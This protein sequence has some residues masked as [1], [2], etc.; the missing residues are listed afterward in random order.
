MLW[1][2]GEERLEKGER[3]A[4]GFAGLGDEAVDNVVA[5]LVLVCEALQERV[6]GEHVAL[7]GRPDKAER[8]SVSHRASRASKLDARDEPAADHSDGIHR[9]PAV[10]EVPG[11]SKDRKCRCGKR[12]AVGVM[13]AVAEQLN[14]ER[15]DQVKG[16]ARVVQDE[17]RHAPAL[18]FEEQAAAASE[19]VFQQV[20]EEERVETEQEG[21]DAIDVRVGRDK[22]KVGLWLLRRAVM[23]RGIGRK[24]W[25]AHDDEAVVGE[26]AYEKRAEKRCPSETG[27]T[28][29][30]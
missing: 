6:D 3:V 22:D 29:T 30:E 17:G 16:S 1:T 7:V 14:D 21:G 12:P 2:E 15:E 18:F 27:D 26:R 13:A 4:V 20:P 19:G 24:Y 8:I 9:L 23:C 11:V 28:S 5:N 10:G 25:G